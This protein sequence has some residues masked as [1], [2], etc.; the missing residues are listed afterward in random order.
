MRWF[1]LA[2]A[3]FAGVPAFAQ[4]AGVVLDDAGITAVVPATP[5]TTPS[6]VID[7]GTVD[8]LPTTPAAAVST[9]KIVFTAVKDGNWWLAAAGILLLIV[10]LLRTL[11]RKFHDWLPD[12]NI[13]D[14][15]LI[16]LYDTKIGGWLL[17]WLTAT[18]GGVGTAIAAGVAVDWS[19]WK[20]VLIVSTSG[21]ALFELYQDIKEWWVARQ[22]AKKAAATPTPAVEPPKA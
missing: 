20:S 1:V 7:G 22:A 16:F 9:V 15:P 2:V 4:D 14:K 3:L 13:M 5:A 6:V 12:N 19:V 18:A 8:V 21:T 10:G 11:G 17:N